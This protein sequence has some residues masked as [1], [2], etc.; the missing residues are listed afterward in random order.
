MPSDVCN[1]AGKL[2]QRSWSISPFGV[3]YTPL[4]GFVRR[5]G[6]DLLHPSPN[7]E[8]CHRKSRIAQ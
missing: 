2:C 1:E 6:V 8:H 5:F 3:G 4:V 7:T